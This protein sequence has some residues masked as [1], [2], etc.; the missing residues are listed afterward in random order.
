MSDEQCRWEQWLDGQ[1]LRCQMVGPHRVHLFAQQIRD[2]EDRHS[3][4]PEQARV[5]QGRNWIRHDNYDPRD[6]MPSI[7]DC[8]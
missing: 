3:N 8:I 5:V 6:E 7:S 1:L 2:H 4:T